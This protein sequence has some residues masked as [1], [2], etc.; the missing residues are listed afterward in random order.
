MGKFI[1]DKKFINENIFLYENRLESQY[2]IF[3]D[4]KTPTFTTY[5]HINNINSITDSGLMNVEKVIGPQ[6]PIRFQKIDDFPIYTSEPIKLDLSDNDEGLNTSFESD[7]II[8]PNTIKPLPNDLFTISY[9]GKSYIFMITNVEYDTIKSN[10]FYKINFT[11]RHEDNIDIIKNQILETYTCVFQ[12][13]GTDDKCIIRSD[14]YD[15]LTKLG[16]WYKHISD[17]YKT[18]F[19]NTRYNS[20]LFDE[21]NYRI[22]DRY[23][24]QFITENQLFINKDGYDTLRLINEDYS[25]RADIE[26]DVSLYKMLEEQDHT[27]LIPQRAVRFPISYPDSIFNYYRDR[28]IRSVSFTVTGDLEYISDKLVNDIKDNFVCEHTGILEEIIIKHFN[29]EY[30]GVYNLR[31]DNLM[32]YKI[33][34]TYHDFL[35]IPMVM[36]IIREIMD[37]VMKNEGDDYYAEHTSDDA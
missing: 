21:G 5:Y 10:N 18:I 34:Y 17:R 36:Y 35:L 14:E 31:L 8:L 15:A 26:Y 11:I 29:K 24:T 4:G 25:V 30:H 13:I 6:S 20:F 1:E 2:T 7:G 27:N 37:M 23:L 12:N 9:L 32:G 28:S 33:K 19:Y 16:E 3:F 22:Y